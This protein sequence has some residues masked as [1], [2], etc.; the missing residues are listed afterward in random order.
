MPISQPKTNLPIDKIE[1]SILYGLTAIFLFR[2]LVNKTTR[3]RALYT[4]IIIASAYGAAMEFLQYLIP[5]R[6]F[7]IGDMAANTSGA[8]IFCIVYAKRHPIKNRM[9]D[10]AD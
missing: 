3:I 5:Q 4:S 2:H 6:G 7:S 8:F 10:Y 1:H 9:S